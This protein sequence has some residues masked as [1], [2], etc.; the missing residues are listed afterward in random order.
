MSPVTFLEWFGI[1]VLVAITCV[2]FLIIALAARREL[3]K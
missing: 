3:R 2:V 1:G